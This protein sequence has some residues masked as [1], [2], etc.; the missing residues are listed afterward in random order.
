M[1]S[2]AVSLLA[3][4]AMSVGLFPLL[5]APSTSAAPFLVGRVHDSFNPAKGKIYAL[6]IGTDAR[7]GN[8]NSRND[9]IH[10]VGINTKTMKGGI[11]N[12]PRDSW[13]NIPGFGSSR[14]NEAVPKGGPELLAK[15]VE[16]MTGI[17]I[18]YWI[19]TGFVGF[20][21]AVKEIGGVRM[22]IPSPVYDRGYSGANLKAGTYRLKGYQAL[23]YARARHS[24]GEG[25]LARTRNQ[26]RILLAL[27]AKLRS[28][29][30]ESPASLLKWMSVARKHTRLGIT[31][32]EMFRLGVLA[33]QVKPKD[34]GNVTVPVSLGMMGAA[35]VVFIRSEAQLI[36]KRFREKGSL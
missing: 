26:A 17:R 33:S 4:I 20:Q 7:S 15:T 32:D 35:S 21:G 1:R 11:L 24:F 12:F 19:M 13:V 6:I 14:I 8:P 25:D 18:D 29:V 28:E 2:R 36:Y 16:S 27:L 10:L 22:H 5:D 34:V 3:V 9:A 31:P 30:A 23:A